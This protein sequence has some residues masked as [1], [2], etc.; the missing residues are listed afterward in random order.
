[1]PKQIAAEGWNNWN[2]PE[3]EKTVYYAEYKSRGEG[4]NTK[5]RASWSKQL[6]DKEEKE[7]SLE[8]IFSNANVMAQQDLNW[9]QNLRTIPFEFKK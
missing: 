8:T 7:Y 3:N 5:S 6:T 1:M 4:A 9:F 2:N